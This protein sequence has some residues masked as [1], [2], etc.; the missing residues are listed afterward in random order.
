LLVVA[1]RQS[2][3]KVIAS[4]VLTSNGT[5]EWTC[6]LDFTYSEAPMLIDYIYGYHSLATKVSAGGFAIARLKINSDGELDEMKS[7]TLTKSASNFNNF[8]LRGH[9]IVDSV[10]V[11]LL[12]YDAS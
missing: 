5:V 1:T 4:R 8:K 11:L 7:L 9:H 2:D 6:A 10:R 3:R 12:F